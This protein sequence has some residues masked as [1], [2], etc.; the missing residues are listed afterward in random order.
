MNF[1]LKNVCSFFVFIFSLTIILPTIAIAQE[2]EEIYYYENSITN[3]FVDKIQLASGPFNP[4]ESISGFFEIFNID[5]NAIS[6]ISYRVELVYLVDVDG[7]F[8]PSEAINTSEISS[9]MTIPAEGSVR[10]PFIYQSPKNIPEGE[11]GLLIQ[12][13]FGNQNPSAYEIIPIE[14]TGEKITLLERS[15]FIVVNE[16]EIFDL[17]TGP[18]IRKDEKMEFLAIILNSTNS[19]KKISTNLKIFEGNNSNTTPI[20]ET[21]LDEVEI[22]P[23]EESEILIDVDIK[24]YNPAVYTVLM[25]FKD[26][27]NREVVLPI[28]SRFIVAGAKPKIEQVKYNTTDLTNAASFDVRVFYM[29]APYDFRINEDGTPRDSRYELLNTERGVAL[30]NMSAKVLVKNIADGK[31]LAEQNIKFESGA[32]EVARFEPFYNLYGLNIT[33][34]LFENGELVDTYTEDISVTTNWYGFFEKYFKFYPLETILVLS[35]VV[36][37]FIG[38]IISVILRRRV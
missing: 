6:N 21:N 34:E 5:Q 31:I 33:V 8:H 22:K 36:I 29:D 10:V 23:D 9:P 15:G 7:A 28:E 38:L 25:T 14:F 18:T 32:D 20:F 16:D 35:I 13:Y 30:N 26:E 12:T 17:L 11:L 24:E 1:F 3:L 4:G 19:D 2:Q 27:Q 37:L